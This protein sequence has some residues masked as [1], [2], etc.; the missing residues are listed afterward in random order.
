[1]TGMYLNN[2][3]LAF[4]LYGD[5]SF[6]NKDV[7]VNKDLKAIIQIFADYLKTNKNDYEFF[8]KYGS[9]YDSY[10]GKGITDSLVNQIQKKIEIDLRNLSIV[11]NKAINVV[12]LQTGNNT[13][14][15]RVF[16]YKID[17]YTLY[18]TINKNEGMLIDY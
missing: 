9:D 13:V 12:A 18:I 15:V 4:D 1:M 17:E 14:E 10:I 7:I 6:N 11:P 16:L 3:T 5:I 2:D 8:E